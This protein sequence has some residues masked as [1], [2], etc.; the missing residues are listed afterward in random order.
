MAFG[1]CRDDR[2]RVF[3]D[4]ALFAPACSPIFPIPGRRAHDARF[5]ADECIAASTSITCF[6]I[7]GLP[8]RTGYR[9][10]QISVS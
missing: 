2:I 6:L 5:S 4:S 3:V 1:Y 8:S 10:L 7:S 9:R